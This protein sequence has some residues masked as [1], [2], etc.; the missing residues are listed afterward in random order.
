MKKREY[1]DVVII[2][3]EPGKYLA[4]PGKSDSEQLIGMP[5]RLVLKNKNNIP[6]FEEREV[7]E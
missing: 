7:I 5:E 1:D 6:E 4:I 2:A 3:A